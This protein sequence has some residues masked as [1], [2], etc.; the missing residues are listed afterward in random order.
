M[1]PHEPAR[2]H[3]ERMYRELADSAIAYIPENLR[4]HVRRTGSRFGRLAAEDSPDAIF[5][6]WLS[7]AVRAENVLRYASGEATRLER[8]AA[9]VKRENIAKI[10]A[11]QAERLAAAAEQMRIRQKSER[12]I[13]AIRAG[14]CFS[15][16]ASTVMTT[17][18]LTWICSRYVS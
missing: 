9:Q 18:A 14:N 10:A 1:Y 13:A 15:G 6:K 4:R 7:Y 2:S 17:G 12:R 3:A 8:I 5:A 11:E 16:Y